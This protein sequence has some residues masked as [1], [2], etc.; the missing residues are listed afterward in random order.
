MIAV[1]GESTGY[2]ALKRIRRLMQLDKEGQK[3][4]RLLVWMQLKL[5]H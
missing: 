5:L 2:Y 3:I 4:L 1:L